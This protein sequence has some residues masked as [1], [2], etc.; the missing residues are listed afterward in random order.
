MAYNY[1][2]DLEPMST[3][4][5]GCVHCGKP[6]RKGDLALCCPDCAAIFCEDCVR[7]GTFE[8]HSCEDYD[9]E[10]DYEEE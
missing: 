7:D 10:D 8:N 9:F 6:I 5:F 3:N 1:I 2:K 4:G